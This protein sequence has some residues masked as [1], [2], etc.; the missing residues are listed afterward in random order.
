MTTTVSTDREGRRAWCLKWHL[1][2]LNLAVCIAHR[3][4]LRPQKRGSSWNE[5]L[6]QKTNHMAN[7]HKRKPK[8]YEEQ[9]GCCPICG[10]PF[11]QS[12]MQLHHVLPL[13]R[14][15]ELGSS[16]DNLLLVC[17]ACHQ[18]IHRNPFLN[19][20]LMVERA[21]RLGIDLSQRYTG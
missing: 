21:C 10:K 14:Y 19:S 12:E 20:R 11:K 2:L 15:P 4:N 9:G 1:P 16:R 17:P 5:R 6:R 13:E 8:M 18:E 7:C 3:L